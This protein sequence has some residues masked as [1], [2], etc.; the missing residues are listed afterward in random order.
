MVHKK[1]NVQNKIVIP[2]KLENQKTFTSQHWATENN[3]ST[4]TARRQL[5]ELVKNGLLEFTPRGPRS[6]YRVKATFRH[7]N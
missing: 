7:E 4:R 2:E 5:A 3:V 1:L 6:L